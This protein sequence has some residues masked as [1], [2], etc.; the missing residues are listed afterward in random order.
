MIPT[1]LTD[2]ILPVILWLKFYPWFRQSRY[3]FSCYFRE[4]VLFCIRL[5]NPA[6]I[7]CEEEIVA[8]CERRSYHDSLNNVFDVQL[9]L[10]Q[11]MKLFIN[12]VSL[13]PIF[14]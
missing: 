14:Y 3:S 10:N 4:C 8:K 1:Q 12:T 6:V 13:S 7:F 5:R 9:H 2:L 11:L